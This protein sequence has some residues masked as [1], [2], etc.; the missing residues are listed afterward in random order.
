[1]PRR[2]SS[3]RLF[4]LAE[5][6]TCSSKR[7]IDERESVYPDEIGVDEYAVLD[8]IWFTIET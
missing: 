8:D 7:F 5:A 6:E 1:M 4:A 3:E 2:T